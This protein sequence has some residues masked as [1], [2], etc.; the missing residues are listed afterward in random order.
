MWKYLLF[1]FKNCL[2]NRRRSFLTIASI[3]LSL[4]LLGILVAIYHAFYYRS[5]PPEEALRLVTRNR[6]SLTF[7]LPEYYGARIKQIA[8]VREVVPTSWFGGIYIDNRP[9]HFFPRFATDPEK[10]FDVYPEYKILPEQ[11][12]A[13]QADRTSA[14]IGR[15]LAKKM[16]F[17]MGQKI[18]I[19]GDIYPVDIELTIRAIFDGPKDSDFV[20]YFHRKYLEEGLS[21][22]LKGTVGTFAMM[23]DSADSVPRIARDVDEMFRNSDRQ[24]KTESEHAFALSFVSMLG[25]VKLFLLSICGAVVFTILLVSANTMAMS[26]RERVKEIGVLKTLGFTRGNV[27][28]MIVAESVIIAML[29]G[30]LGCV[31][32]Y[33]VCL[34]LTDIQIMFGGLTM[35]PVVLAISLLVAFA[36]GLLSSAIPAWHASRLPITEAL[37][38]VG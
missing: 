36:I 26:V 14:A 12:K 2:R 8:G 4:F 1:A 17:S 25:N 27:L 33:V 32:A 5:G 21:E 9:E 30:F 38:H 16:N 20:L 28:T 34:G 13:F 23:A 3:G 37:R 15:Y 10:I 6:V 29:G 35:P 18:T 7:S 24:T 31:L 11:L 19:K 22:S